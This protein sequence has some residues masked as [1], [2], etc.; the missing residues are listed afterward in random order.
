MPQR[1]IQRP[2]YPI[3]FV[4]GFASGMDEV[5]RTTA[6]PYMGFNEGATMIRQ[7]WTGEVVK[8]VFESPLVRL[9]KDHGYRDVYEAGLSAEGAIPAKSVVIHRYYEESSTDFGAGQK[10]AIEH[11]AQRLGELIDQLRDQVC[12]G[13]ARARRDFRVYLVA[14]SMGGLICRCLLQNDQIGRPETKRLVDKVFTYA[15]P[16][17][18]IDF[19]LL[20]NVPAFLSINHVNNFSRPRMARYLG[21]AADDRAA[22]RLARVD[23][24][25]GKFD[26]ARF[27]CL[28][29]TNFNDYTVAHG[30]SSLAVGP[31]S[32]GLVAIRN[33]TVEGSPRAF[34]HWSGSCSATCASTGC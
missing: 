18:G 34:V 26:P 11:Y 6:T 7:L 19:Q 12:Q 10:H 5:D 17:N 4:R 13:D 24:L 29:G 33:A 20:G 2:F 31:M 25:A 22:G 14:H 8:H 30:L 16:H 23:S 27:F 15:T 1:L 21:L 28:V 9:M 3:V 32:D